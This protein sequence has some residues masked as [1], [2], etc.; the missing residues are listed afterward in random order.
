MRTDAAGC[1]LFSRKQLPW[2]TLALAFAVYVLCQH[3]QVY[4]YHDDYGVGALSYRNSIEGFTRTDFNQWQL[5]QFLADM[6]QNWSSR[7]VAFYIQINLTSLG[8]E[9]VRAWQLLTIGVFVVIS[10][11]L[12]G[13]R[14][15]FQPLLVVPVMFYLALPLFTTAGGLYWFS[16]AGGYFWGVP[17]FFYGL[18]RVQQQQQLDWV[19]TV[20]FAFA[21]GF[22]ELLAITILVFLGGHYLMQYWL[23]RSQG[24]FKPLFL[25]YLA[26]GVPALIFLFAPG[27]FARS[28]VSEYAS[29]SRW[30]LFL[31]NMGVLSTL[32]VHNQYGPSPDMPY[33]EVWPMHILTGASLGVLWWMW[34]GQ[35]SYGRV[36]GWLSKLGKPWSIGMLVLGIVILVLIKKWLI[37]PIL[38]AYVALLGAVV[39]RSYSGMVIWLGFVAASFVLLALTQSP[40]VAGRSLLLYY[41][42]VFP[43]VLYP[44]A[45]LL[46]RGRNGVFAVLMLVATPLALHNAY[47]VYR[48]YADNDP[49]NQLN[50]AILDAAGLE[51]SLYA[52]ER[53]SIVL[54]RLP[55]PRFAETMPYDAVYMD[56]WMRK[57]YGLSPDQRMEWQ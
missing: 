39:Y 14:T 25:R 35:S 33:Q 4:F 52:K 47:V 48:G 1:N 13:A 15:V 2:M 37:V 31:H 20:A 9:Y 29:D 18:Y 44:F 21:A 3:L 5:L 51:R 42:L 50:H 27:N 24:L 49:V 45:H 11:R 22:H 46:S 19:G 26:G 57:F 28:A 12:V 36:K 43:A 38:L 8:V 56:S 53:E 55:R 41:A 17:L 32:L 40:W 16:A 10:M 7:V 6:F 54:Y 30:E 23:M 34:R